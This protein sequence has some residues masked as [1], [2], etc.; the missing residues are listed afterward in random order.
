MSDTSKK[1]DQLNKLF[2][3][4]YMNKIVKLTGAT[5]SIGMSYYSKIYN[6]QIGGRWTENLGVAI[7]GTPFLSDKPETPFNI[8]RILKNASVYEFNS[9]RKQPSYGHSTP[10]TLFKLQHHIKKNDTKNV[11]IT[12]FSIT[13]FHYIENSLPVKFVNLWQKAKKPRL[14]SRP[15]RNP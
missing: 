10:R 12:H 1:C 13:E 14:K 8:D 15:K 2:L 11:K 7:T 3:F 5:F 6:L 4:R 9:L